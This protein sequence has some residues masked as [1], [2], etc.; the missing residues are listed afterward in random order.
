MK[1]NIA[2]SYTLHVG[3]KSS[4]QWH[5][6]NKKHA[7]ISF[8]IYFRKNGKL[9][10]ESFVSVRCLKYGT[11]KHVTRS[12]SWTMA[13]KERLTSKRT[14]RHTRTANS[15][16]CLRS[17]CLRFPFMASYVVG[18][19]KRQRLLGLRS[20]DSLIIKG[21]K[22]VWQV[23][24]VAGWLPWTKLVIVGSREGEGER[25]FVL[26]QHHSGL[27]CSFRQPTF[28]TESICPGTVLSIK[29]IPRKISNIWN[30][31]TT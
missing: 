31:F 4:Q 10:Y 25:G 22:R 18:Q 11:L 23:A 12:C 29:L 3:S 21:K 15:C 8:A 30:K 19:I 26:S 1:Y 28:K 20:D 13:R 16:I 27:G 14:W 17:P 24:L 9:W 2:S 7:I 5:D 6:D